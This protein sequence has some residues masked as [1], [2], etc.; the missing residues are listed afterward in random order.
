MAECHYHPDKKGTGKCPECK[1]FICDRC[2]INGTDLRCATCQSAF[3]KGNSGGRR[4][5]RVYCLQHKDTVAEKRCPGCKRPYC[6][7]CVNSAGYCQRCVKKRLSVRE[8]GQRR[9]TLG[10]RL[11]EFVGQ[12]LVQLGFAF[13]VVLGL[14]FVVW[15]GK[16]RQPP[17]VKVYRGKA[18]VAFQSPKPG[19]VAR[20]NVKIGLR[21]TPVEQVEYV[22]IKIDGKPWTILKR[23]PF[24]SEWP[25][26]IFRPGA[27]RL[28]A[29][30]V[31]RGRKVVAQATRDCQVVK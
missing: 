22:E 15:S 29:R 24:D 28:T 6:F 7:A 30:A 20:G 19:A 9:L 17:V 11:Q 31:F 12:P 10:E 8:G 25:T 4:S 13:V 16:H 3:K 1:R 18:S 26:A 23:A 14:V 27:H 5:S 21:V 2:R